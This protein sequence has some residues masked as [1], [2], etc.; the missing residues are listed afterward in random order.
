MTFASTFVP[1]Y[2][3]GEWRFPNYLANIP[4]P[5][6]IVELLIERGIITPPEDGVGA[7]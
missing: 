6:G 3:L 2:L 4:V 7:E 5:D 1:E